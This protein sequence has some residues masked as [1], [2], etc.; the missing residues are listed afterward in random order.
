M[1]VI[2]MIP[3]EHTGYNSFISQC[4]GVRNNAQSL[5]IDLAV[6][7]S[8][9]CHYALHFIWILWR[10]NFVATRETLYTGHK[11]WFNKAT[12]SSTLYVCLKLV[13]AWRGA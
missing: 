12:V 9:S 13:V 3:S 2:A 6:V 4:A 8:S 5:W 7:S 1:S 11:G 10:I